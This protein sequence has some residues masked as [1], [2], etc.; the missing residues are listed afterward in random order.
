MVLPQITF[1]YEIKRFCHAYLIR[2]LMLTKEVKSAGQSSFMTAIMTVISVLP[3]DDCNVT[4]TINHTGTNHTA[5]VRNIMF[6]D[7]ANFL[8]G[9]SLQ[10]KTVG[11]L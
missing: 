6:A 7:N 11:R 4:I 1:T 10:R 8:T 2:I 5:I 3:D 9:V